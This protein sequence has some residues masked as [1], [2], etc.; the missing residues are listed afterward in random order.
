[1]HKTL[2]EWWVTHRADV[3]HCCITVLG[4]LI[5]FVGKELMNRHRLPFLSAPQVPAPPE[6]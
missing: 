5:M 2:N 6:D 1:M 3:T 4:A